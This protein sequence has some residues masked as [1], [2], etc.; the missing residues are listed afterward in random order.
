MPKEADMC[1]YSLCGLPN[2]LAMEDEELVVHKFR[3]GSVGLASPADLRPRAWDS[4]GSPRNLWHRFKAF[5]EEAAGSPPVVTA[6]CIP[7][8]AQ[9][10]IESISEDLRRRWNLG[11]H[12][13]ACF[14]Q[15]SADVNR[16]RD[17]VDFRSGRRVLLQNLREGMR[18]RVVS[19]NGEYSGSERELAT[20]ALS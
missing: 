20:P 4:P 11:D 10:L 6:V 1:D 18:V 8:G 15:I 5:L 19:L 12:E 9:L 14:I 16:Y 17:A 2:R 3:T 13:S 7:P